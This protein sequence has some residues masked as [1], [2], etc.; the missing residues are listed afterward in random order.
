MPWRSH[1]APDGIRVRGQLMTVIAPMP[2]AANN[3]TTTVPK[4]HFSE[5]RWLSP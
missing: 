3:I 5:T 2:I 4:V 1:C